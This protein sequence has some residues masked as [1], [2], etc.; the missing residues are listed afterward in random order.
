M[1][2]QGDSH[3]SPLSDG[4]RIAAWR[5]KDDADSVSWE[6]TAIL[7]IISSLLEAVDAVVG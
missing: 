1:M 3:V 5:R 4:P 6:M 7:T 2:A